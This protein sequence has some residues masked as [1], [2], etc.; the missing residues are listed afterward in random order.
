MDPNAPFPQQPGGMPG[1]TPGMNQP[2]G[3]APQTREEPDTSKKA[4]KAKKKADDADKAPTRKLMSTQRLLALALGALAVVLFLFSQED[5]GPEQAFVVRTAAPVAAMSNLNAS[6][7]EAVVVPEEFIESG[8]F[9]A[10]SAEEALELALEE[11]EGDLYQYPV[12]R[13]RQITADMFSLA[14]RLRQD[15]GPD[16]RLISVPASIARSVGAN[17]RVGDR[18]DVIGVGSD[19]VAT[20]ATDLEIVAITLAE[21]TFGQ[22]VTEQTREEGRDTEVAELVPGD[23]V[24]GTY[25]LRVGVADANRLALL[26]Q[27]AQLIFTYRAPGAE[28]TLSRPVSILEMLCGLDQADLDEDYLDTLPD[29]CRGD[30]GEV[31]YR[32]GSMGD[33][34]GVGGIVDGGNTGGSG[35]D[36]FNDDVFIGDEDLAGDE[37]LDD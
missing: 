31:I 20:V 11:H 29:E 32:G 8:A 10:E 18:V 35:D 6:Q 1:A 15:L 9:V 30:D 24:P 23:P 25:T 3:W 14:D 34:I 28:S 36:L 2:G 4:K 16:E 19:V 27:E 12:S 7:L 17:L 5:P 37:G 21:D 33:G 13:G 22:L 26:A